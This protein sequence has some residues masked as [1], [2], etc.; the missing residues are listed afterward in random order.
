MKLK[1]IH[2]SL[3]LI[4]IIIT[5]LSVDAVQLLS[6]EN[7]LKRMFLTAESIK[8]EKVVLT[9]EQMESVKK[10]L[11]GKLYLMKGIDG[12]KENEYTFYTAY[13]GEQIIGIAIIEA[14]EDKWG[15][16]RFIVVID[17]ASNTV[18]N[19]A[20]MEYVDSRARNLSNRTFLKRFIGKG[21]GDLLQIN[22]DIDAISGATVSTEVLCFIVKKVIALH[23]VVYS[24]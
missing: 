23:S 11:G 7:A 22:R 18:S 14:Q 16:L 17:P 15:A 9:S 21:A 4:I 12:T 6:K 19:L 20:L 13:K 3:S 24:K 2:K 1:T 8:E 10:M 5:S